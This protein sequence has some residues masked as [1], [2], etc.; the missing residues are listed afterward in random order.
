MSA[1]VRRA[2]KPIASLFGAEAQTTTAAS[3]PEPPAAPPTPDSLP[4]DE[5]GLTQTQR[6]AG[7]LKRR[8]ANPT[9]GLL[10]GSAGLLTAASVAK[11]KITGL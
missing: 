2:T 10:T 6:D 4:T 8:G 5:N 3:P 1:F 9:M 11:P 7:Q